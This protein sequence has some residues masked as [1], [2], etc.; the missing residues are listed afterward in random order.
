MAIQRNR[1]MLSLGL[2]ALLATTV[3]AAPTLRDFFRSPPDR[4]AELPDDELYPRGRQFLFTYFSTYHGR[5]A[6]AEVEQAVAD[7]CT[8]I[9]PDYGNYDA[10]LAT[11]EQYGVKYFMPV[12]WHPEGGHKSLHFVD[13]SHPEFDADVVREAVAAKVASYADNDTVAGWYLIPEEMRWWRANE[14]QF[15][16]AVYEGVRQG[17]PKKR[18]VWMYEPN[19]RSAESLAKT[20]KFQDIC[21]KGIYTNYAGKQDERIWVRWSIEQEVQAIRALGRDD[22]IAIAVAEMFQQPAD[23]VVHMVPAWARHDA[24]LSLVSGA[25]G[26]IIFSSAHRRG[27]T[28]RDTYYEAYAQVSRELNGEKQLG[29]IFLFGEHRD[30]LSVRVI[31]GPA[32]VTLTKTPSATMENKTKTYP[33]ISILDIAYDGD[34]YLFAVNSANEPVKAVVEGLPFAGFTVEAVFNDENPKLGRGN[35]ATAFEPLEVKAWRFTRGK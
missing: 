25:Q 8:M 16:Q 27:F 30:D 21:G 15:M 5:D 4:A 2:I 22:A 17:D 3:Q 33:S 29:Q 9:G 28:A 19:N 1:L 26:V 7:G 12:G 6:N 14:M 35:F 20:L 32:T 13:D 31:N 18:P 11:A 24:Y 23:D 10:A 34:R